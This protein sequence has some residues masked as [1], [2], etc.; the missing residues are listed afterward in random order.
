MLQSEVVVSLT[1]FVKELGLAW[2]K[3][4]IYQPGHPERQQALG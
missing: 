3:L 2:Q 4:A 1:S